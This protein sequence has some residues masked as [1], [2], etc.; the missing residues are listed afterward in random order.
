MKTIFIRF[1]LLALVL[2]ILPGCSGNTGSSGANGASYIIK[3]WDNSISPTADQIASW[4]ALAPQVTI[5]SVS[6]SGP[7]VVKFTVKDTSGNAIAGLGNK[8]QSST[9]TVAGLTNIAFTF[10][11]LVPVTG[12]PAKWVSYNVIR[13]LTVAE[14]TSIPSTASCNA[15]KTWCGT[16]PATDTQGALVDNGD[17][18]YQYTFLRDPT[19]VAT[20][21][22]GLTDSADGLSLKA[23]LGDLAFDAGK[24]H[25]LGIQIGGAAPG[26]GS[27]NPTATS[28]GM[29][30]SVNMLNPSNVVY[31][32]RP[33]GGAISSTR[34]IAVIESCADCHRGKVLAHGS[35]KDPKYCVTCHTDQ[36]R[37]SFNQEASS[38]GGGLT[39]TGTTRQTTAV[40]AG[41]ALGN[42]PNMVHHLHMGEELVKQGYYFNASAEGKFN[43]VKFPQDQRNCIKCH[44]GS[45]TKPDGS[46]NTSKTADGD[47]WKNLPSRLAC[48]GCH[49]GIDFAAAAGTAGSVTLADRDA[50]VAAGKPV[51]TTHSGHQ[52]GVQA[53]DSQ[54][55]TCHTASAMQITHIPVTP[56]DLASALHVAAGNGN[57]NA[58][59]VASNTSNLPAGAIKVTYDIKSVSRDGTTGNP[60]MVFRMLQNG[61]PVAFN[62]PASKTE[63]WDNFMGAPSVY[64]VYAVPQDG[65]TAPADFNASAS[66]YLRD[67]WNCNGSGCVGSKGTLTGPDGS[68]YYTATIQ[69]AFS[70][71]GTRSAVTIP[72]NAVM[73]T[74]GLGYSYSLATTMPLT[75]TNV[76]GYPA[77]AS[78][79]A[80]CT[81]ANNVPYAGCLPAVCTGAGPNLT[82]PYAG[83][84]AKSMPNMTGG[85]MVVTPDAQKVAANYSGRRAIVEDVRCNKCHQELGVFAKDTFH[86]AQRNDGTTCSWCHTPNRTSSGWS[87]D[88]TYHIHAIH[89]GYDTTGTGATVNGINKRTV[90][91]TWHAGSSTDGTLANSD[92]F[93][94]IGFPGVLKTCE[95]CHLP[96]TY[97]FSATASASALP[98]KQF[99]TVATGYYNG[100]V[101]TL[102]TGCTVTP[103]N[104]CLATNLSVL[105][106]SP[107][108][109]KDNTTNYGSGFSV[110]SAGT[111]TQAA[112]TTLVNSPITSVCF[113]CH[114]TTLAKT[115]MEAN[116]GYIYKSRN[117]VAGGTYTGTLANNEQCMLC[118]GTGRVADIKAMHDK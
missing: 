22:A 32:F 41:R 18:T 25:R 39:L 102:T 74:G 33:D 34:D 113:A 47:N 70:S 56:P 29:P 68:G 44:D 38:S 105:S 2:A 67:L 36:I 23:D 92:G 89:A 27:N 26:T 76:T 65:I 86:A 57:T 7:P 6:V 117:V 60:V 80:Q 99:R 115:H 103:T 114:D 28:T 81:S 35:R 19:Q 84:V 1:S 104:D 61:T 12:G 14:K 51:G 108:V 55:S 58:A 64:F 45:A 71:S 78:P 95:T 13:P 52:G 11:K 94:K 53:D 40:V 9:A 73:L 37:Y 109:T 63:I 43:E 106:I 4:K 85:M 96:G 62:D 112:G 46:T 91:Y 72:A 69:Y 101:G 66:A 10:A 116:G 20:I 15:D 24:T 17:G 107:Y 79:V 82:T 31:D 54:C 88:S 98:N 100:T 110:N 87:A 77:A 50:D 118:H 90:P 5:T 97:D 8:S 48:G 16:Y 49:D 75:Q 42:Y 21:V 111:A 3:I 83:C 93:W 30:A 59:S